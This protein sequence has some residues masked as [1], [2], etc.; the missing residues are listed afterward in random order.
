MSRGQSLKHFHVPVIGGSRVTTKAGH[1]PLQLAKTI[2]LATEK[3]SDYETPR[4]WRAARS[5]MHEV[6]AVDGDVEDDGAG[7]DF[8][9]LGR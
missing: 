4:S 7:V 5:K 6:N 8:H 2:L 1:Y 9:G 3:Q